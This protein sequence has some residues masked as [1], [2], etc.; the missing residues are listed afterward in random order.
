MGQL[1]EPISSFSIKA[2]DKHSHSHIIFTNIKVI[3]ITIKRLKVLFSYGKAR[4]PN[5]FAPK[6]P[7]PF[8]RANEQL[9]IIQ[10]GKEASEEQ[11]VKTPFQNIV[12]EE[13]QLDEEDEIHCMEDKGSAAFLTLAAYEESLLKDQTSEEWDR[14]AIL[15]TEDQQR[16]NLRS[17]T[18]NVKERPA[19]RVDVPREQQSNK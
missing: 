13:E 17:R 3:N 18:S 2:L 7:N 19:Q 6:N 5:T 4:L 8:R 1:S 11:R 10:R 16:Y 9:Q 12:M 15:Q 14:E